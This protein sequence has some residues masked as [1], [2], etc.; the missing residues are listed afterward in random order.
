M[1]NRKF[2]IAAVAGLLSALPVKARA[3]V[4]AAAPKIVPTALAVGAT[5]LSLPGVSH[6]VDPVVTVPDYSG[7]IT[8]GSTYSTTLVATYGAGILLIAL[9]FRGFGWVYRKV[10]GNIH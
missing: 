10:T 3:S 6:A 7:L 5:V 1:L 4:S 8:A 9:T 2:S